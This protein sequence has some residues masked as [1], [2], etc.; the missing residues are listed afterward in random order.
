[1]HSLMQPSSVCVSDGG[2][3]NLRRE[4]AKKQE[5]EREK[6][7]SG[8]S[9]ASSDVS[10]CARPAVSVYRLSAEGLKEELE[11]L[12]LISRAGH[13]PADDDDDRRDVKR[14]APP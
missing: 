9:R 13:F 6:G 1:M 7:M 5:R 12:R 2:K 8:V 10:L 11:S 14:R 4:T 3:S